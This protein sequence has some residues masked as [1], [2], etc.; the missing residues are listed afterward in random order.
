MIA[1]ALAL[2]MAAAGG[3]NDLDLPRTLSL[4]DFRPFAAEPAAQPDEFA[5]FVTLHIGA[6]GA[7]DADHP[8]FLFG[9]GA[10]VHILPWLGADA[11]IDFQT[12][13]KVTDDGANASIFQVPFMFAGLFYPPFELPFRP[14]GAFGI[15][16][17]ITDVT[18]P[19]GSDDTDANLL[20]FLGFGAEFELSSNLLVTADLRFVFAQDPPHSRDFS[21]D[22]AQFTIGLALRLS[23]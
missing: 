17:T 20:F 4:D 22:W 8:A 12:K 18:L 9:A 13:Q 16:W 14:Y 6:A 23:K 11:S 3:P 19:H 2:T 7:Y 5:L 10:R 15:G 21:A 1:L